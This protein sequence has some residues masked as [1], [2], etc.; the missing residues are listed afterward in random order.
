MNRYSHTW[1]ACGYIV[2]IVINR[3]YISSNMWWLRAYVTKRKYRDYYLTLGCDR[4]YICLSKTKTWALY[5][6][7]FF[8]CGDIITSL[9]YLTS[10]KVTYLYCDDWWDRDIHH[11]HR[12]MCEIP[13][14]PKQQS[15]GSIKQFYRESINFMFTKS[16]AKPSKW[17]VSTVVSKLWVFNDRIPVAHYSMRKTEVKA[18]FQ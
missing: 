18:H 17:T 11:S 6:G 13:S 14:V 16:V 10:F 1:H 9:Q 8:Y 15:S 3:A 2:C 12:R 5:H 7:S 4:C